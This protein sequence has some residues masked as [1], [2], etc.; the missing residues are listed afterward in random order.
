[1]R[2]PNRMLVAYLAL[3]NSPAAWLAYLLATARRWDARH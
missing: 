2:I 3:F 1:M